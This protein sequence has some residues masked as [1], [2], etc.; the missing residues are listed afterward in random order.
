MIFS[1]DD[2]ELSITASAEQG[3]PDLTTC[4]REILDAALD[5][6]KV[7]FLRGTDPE[8]RPWERLARST[9]TQRRRKGFS[10]SVIG[11]NTGSLL[12]GLNRGDYRIGPNEASWV[13]SGSRDQI[14]KARGFHA[15]ND[16]NRQPARRFIGWTRQAQITGQAIADRV[17]AGQAE[18]LRAFDSSPYINGRGTDSGLLDGF[19]PDFNS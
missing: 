5:G 3:D 11:V 8:G 1:S 6:M 18:D 10:P 9:I 19:D 14:G 12:D 2:S 16:R 7:T 13:Y 4:G 17:R 15:G